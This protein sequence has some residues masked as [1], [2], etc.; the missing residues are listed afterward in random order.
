MKQDGTRGSV[1]LAIV[2]SRD[3]PQ[4]LLLLVLQK[5]VF[6]HNAAQILQVWHHLLHRE[7]LQKREEQLMLFL[8]ATRAAEV[9][10]QKS[11]FPSL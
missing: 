1:H 4:S 11:S 9:T 3:Q 2:A 8:T 6:G 7:H 10:G 5:E